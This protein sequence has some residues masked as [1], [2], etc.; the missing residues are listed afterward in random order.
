MTETVMSPHANRQLAELARR[1]RDNPTF[2]AS[3]LATYQRQERL[4][5]DA[6]AAQLQTTPEMVVRLALCKRPDASSPQFADQARQIATYTNTDAG[7]LAHIVRRVDSLMKLVQKPKASQSEEVTTQ[8]KHLYH[9]LMAAARDR[10]KTSEDDPA[11]AEDTE[12]P[13]EE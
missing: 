13:Q 8:R 11:S 3:I 12:P 6:L 7:Q 10:T 2:M 5:D 9:G 1:L 4:S